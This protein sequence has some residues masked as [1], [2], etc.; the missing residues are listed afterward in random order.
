MSNALINLR[1]DVTKLQK[2]RFQRGKRGIYADLVLLEKPSEEYGD[3]GFIVEAT[4]K[5]ERDQEK[6]GNIVGN[7]SY[8]KKLM[9]TEPYQPTIRQPPPPEPQAK[10][11]PEDDDIPF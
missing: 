8:I 1:L 5:E 4:T 9:P 10:L 3:D 7:W 6:R 2:D 11:I